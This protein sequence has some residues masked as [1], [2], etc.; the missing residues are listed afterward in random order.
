[1]AYGD[2]GDSQRDSYYDIHEWNLDKSVK[3]HVMVR[4]IMGKDEDSAWQY[5]L[6]SSNR[7]LLVSGDLGGGSLS[8]DGD[9]ANNRVSA[10]QTAAGSLQA[11]AKSGDAGTLLV[12]AK[13]GDAANLMVSG[14]SQDAGL[15]RVSAVGGTAGDNVLVDGDDQSISA[16]V[17]RV[18]GTVSAGANG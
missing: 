3:P 10:F 11:S 12:S 18:S 9:A 4:G 7:R 15:F 13:Q 8:L 6:V 16:T 14:K 1:M 17:Q 5:V 2:A